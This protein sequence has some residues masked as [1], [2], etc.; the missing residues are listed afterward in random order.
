M[1]ECD[2][3]IKLQ[4]ITYQQATLIHK[5]GKQYLAECQSPWPMKKVTV[6]ICQVTSD[7][8][9]SCGLKRS[10]I[11]QKKLH[12]FYSV[13]LTC[14]VQRSKAILK[15]TNMT[16]T[17]AHQFNKNNYYSLINIF[18]Y[19]TISIAPVVNII[20]VLFCYKL[21]FYFSEHHIC[22]HQPQ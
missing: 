6:N 9:L 14:N 18:I 13:F 3:D 2:C 5:L 7:S 22:I 21:K 10:S 8:Y 11:L 20:I 17:K 1:S 16:I 19:L 12:N 15:K 4:S